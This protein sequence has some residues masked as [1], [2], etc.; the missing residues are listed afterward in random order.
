MRLIRLVLF[1]LP[2]M[3]GVSCTPAR[4]DKVTEIENAEERIFG[5]AATEFSKTSADSLV[6]LYTEFA[7]HFP[8]DSLTPDF[9]FRAGNLAMTAGNGK[10]DIGFFSRIISEYPEHPR[11]SMAMFFTAYVQENLFRN[12]DKARETYLLFVEKYPESDFADDAQM[13]LKYLGRS[14][15]QMIREFEKKQQEDSL[16]STTR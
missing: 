16:K 6:A 1:W 3:L 2:V 15:E 8:G 11:S 13:A 10:E 7:D 14:P 12:L 4:N 9:L 5:S